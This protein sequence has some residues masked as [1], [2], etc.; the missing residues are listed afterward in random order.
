MPIMT[1]LHIF[2]AIAIIYYNA[3][4]RIFG[5]AS[6]S[7]AKLS[8]FDSPDYLTKL[9]IKSLSLYRELKMYTSSIRA[10]LDDIMSGCRLLTYR[11][12]DSHVYQNDIRS[13]FSN[14]MRKLN[15]FTKCVEDNEITF[16]FRYVRLKLKKKLIENVSFS[17]SDT[18]KNEFLGAV[19]GLLII[20][21]TYDIDI[22]LFSRGQITPEHIIKRR[23]PLKN[24]RY[25]SL[26]A[27]DLLA[28][29]AHAIN[30]QW[31]KTSSLFVNHSQLVYS[32]NPHLSVSWY[33]N[34]VHSWISTFSSNSEH[35]KSRIIENLFS[36]KY[37]F[38]PFSNRAIGE[39]YPQFRDVIFVY[40]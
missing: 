35:D 37:L 14:T 22:E 3:H 39:S 30:I 4:L 7:Y 26:N 10:L 17:S 34:Y 6:E 33:S 18:P 27:V 28:L 38:L 5:E 36:P 11:Y 16:W 32:E 20:Q 31:Y 40:T 15:G 24:I 21:D 12:M 2:G 25:R 8:I 19:L 9:H 29:S 23:E 1:R 13:V